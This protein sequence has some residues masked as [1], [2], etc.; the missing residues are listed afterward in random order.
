MM[1]PGAPRNRS[2]ATLD[3]ALIGGG[4][5]I[6]GTVRHSVVGQGAV[7]EP[8]ATVS[9]TVVLPG[10]VVGRGATVNR[11]I[12]DSGAQVGPGS[13]IGRA[14]GGV[15]LVGRDERLPPRTDLDAG[16]RIPTPDRS[17]S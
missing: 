8:G 12:L 13:T 2:G 1:E 16:G 9:H 10:V 4:A 11:T 17:Q 6:A 5:D 14:E 3:N 15:A 7:I